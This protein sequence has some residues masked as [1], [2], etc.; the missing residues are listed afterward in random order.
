MRRL[1]RLR[2]PRLYIAGQWVST[3]GDSTLWIAAAIWVKVLTGSNSAAGITF[4][5][6]VLPTLGAPFAGLLVDRLRR[7]PLLIA[8]N[9][10][11]GGAV[12]LLLLVNG[13]HQVWLIWA[14]MLLYGVSNTLLAPAQSALLTVIVPDELLADANGAVQTVNQGLRLVTPLAGAGLFALL[15]GHA[16]AVLDAATFALSVTSL[17]LVR[18]QERA[19][20]REEGHW[21]ESMAAGIR[22]LWGTDQLRRLLIAGALAMAVGGLFETTD[23]AVVSQGLHLPATFVGVV[24]GVEGMGALVGAPLAAPLIRR[25]G[26][27]RVVAAGLLAIAAG[28]LLLTP[29]LLPVVFAGAVCL[30]LGLPWLIVGAM[31]LVQ[32]RTPAALQGRA[33]SALDVVVGTP[34]TISIAV[35]AA[36]ILVVPYQAL[37]LTCAVVLTACGGWLMSRRLDPAEAGPEPEQP[38]GPVPVETGDEER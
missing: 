7:R 3:F 33:V 29:P 9:A 14:V 36:I 31:T 20:Q 34:Q 19:P 1:L 18:V 27:L 15:G 24:I 16:V 6:V 17:L 37:L 4:F 30:G 12:L 8:V 28:A 10:L 21:L 25:M 26:E 35:G 5:F 2:N 11:T 13:P 32:R 23:F 22:H 38:V